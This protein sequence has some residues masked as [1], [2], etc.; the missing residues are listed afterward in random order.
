[1]NIESIRSYCLG[2][3]ATTES[4]PFDDKTLTFKVA[5]KIFAATNLEE[6][7]LR[8]TMKCDPDKAI[9]LRERYKSIEAGYHSNKKHWNTIEVNGE[10]SKEMICQLID[11][12]YQLVVAKLPKK[13][14]EQY[15][16]KL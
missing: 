15:S 4:L 7:P 10:L 16:L 11:H 8:I 9:E 2:K 6:H 5:G 13:I 12:S 14:R 3:K 1:M